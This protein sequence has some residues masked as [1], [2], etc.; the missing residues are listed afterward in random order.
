MTRF[1]LH[2]P[3]AAAFCL[4]LS[5]SGLKL[6]L[7]AG[8]DNNFRSGKVKKSQFG[9]RLQVLEY[10]AFS[11]SLIKSMHRDSTLTS[12]IIL[13]Y[14][15]IIAYASEKKMLFG[16]DSFKCS[17]YYT[18]FCIF[19]EEGKSSL[20]LNIFF[21]PAPGSDSY[22]KTK[23]P[24]WRT[25]NG[26]IQLPLLKN[27]VQ[28]CFEHKSG[29]EYFDSA[30]IKGYINSGSDSFL[31]RPLFKEMP[32]HG[33]KVKPMQVLQGYCLMK[34]DTLYAFLQHAPI[35]KS[36]DKLFL[37]LKVSTEEQMLIAAYFALVSRLVESSSNEPFF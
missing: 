14:S 23:T 21:P 29:E 1:K 11:D 4:L 27:E 19:K 24:Y 37:N 16:T 36:V 32:V 8:L 9:H 13:P 7:P 6:I 35:V 30:H 2:Y 20:L 10:R 28:F 31:I 25:L 5:C 34:G 33:K 26:T 18:I 15:A 22:G 12:G 3:L 17:I